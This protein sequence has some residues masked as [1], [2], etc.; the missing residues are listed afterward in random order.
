MN[1]RKCLI[2][3]LLLVMTFAKN[4]YLQAQTLKNFSHDPVR[5][6]AEMEAFLQATNKKDGEKLMER[7]MVPWTAG[8]FNAAQQETIYSTC[9]AMLK[10]RLKAFPDFSNYLNA[11]IGFSASTQSTQSFDNWHTGINKL[12][13]G[14]VRNFS[15]YLEVCYDLFTSNTLYSSPST[16]WKASNNGYSF[17]FDSLPKIVF[18]NMNLACYA[19]SDSSVIINTQGNYY[20]NLKKFYGKGG[21]VTWNRA[22]LPAKDVYAEL[23]RYQIDVSG[24]DFDADSVTFYN[25]QIFNQPLTGRL[26]EKILAS[27][28]IETATY[29]RFRSYNLNL[30]IKELVKDASYKGGFS[31]HGS[32]MIGSGGRDRAAT[33]IFS[34]SNKPFLKLQAQSFVMRTDRIVSDNAT[35]TFYLETDSIY[36]PGLEFKYIAKERE[37]S[38]IRPSGKSSGTPYYDSYHDIDMYFDAMVWKI[39]DP[40]IDMKMISGEGEVKLVFESSNFF[41]AQRYQRLQGLAEVNPLYTLKQY[42][43]KNQTKVVGVPEYALHLRM[44]EGQ[45]RNLFLALASQGFLT[46]DETTDRA[47]I[48]DRLYYYLSASVGKTD[49]DIIE[50]QSQISGKPNAT[51]NLLN[52]EIN[53]RGVPYVA[54]SD[55]QNVFVVPAEQELT[56]KKDRNFTFNGRV[57]AGRFDFIGKEFTFNYD[58]FNLHLKAVD[59]LSIK[60]PSDEPTADGRIK[61]IPIKSVVQNVTGYLNIDRANNKSSYQ[62]SPEYPIFKSDNQSYVYY[63]YPWIYNS[64]YNRNSFYFQVSPF[65]IDS[66]DNFK[67]EGLS[68]DGSLISAGIFP[69]IPEKLVIQND[70]SL[71][72]KRVLAD[73]GLPAYAGKGTYYEKLNLSNS[74]LRGGGRITYLNSVSESKDIVFFPDS[75]NADLDELVMTRKIIA[76]TEYP[77]GKARDVYMNWRPKNDKMF[78]Y[79]KATNFS[80]Y[81]GKVDHDGDLVLANTGLTG[82]GTISFEQAQILSNQFNFKGITLNADTS[83]F[84]LKSSETGILALSTTNM[85]SFIDFEKRFGEF[86][87]NGKGSY[88]TFPLNQYICYIEKFKW[89]MDDKNVEFGMTANVKDNTE[90]NIAGSEF[91]SINPAQDSLR[92]F[93]PDASY[94]LTD[95]L[96]KA[97]EVKEINVA[98][99]SIIPGDGK[100]V[101]E[102]STYIRTL[103]DA[104]VVANTSTRYHTMINSTINIASK[105]NYSGTGDYEYV[106]QLKVKHLM[107]LTQIG[108]DTSYQTFANGDVEDS[109]NFMLSPNIQYKGRLSIQASRPSP[110]FRGFA[111]ANHNCAALKQNWFGFAAEIDPKGVNVPVKA[112][113]NENG[114]K[115][116]S[117]IVFGKDSANVYATFMSTKRNA[118][119]QEIVSAEGLLSYDNTSKEFRL[120]PPPEEKDK[121]EDKGKDVPPKP[122]NEG[123]SFA[124]N[125]VTCNF[126]GEG[127]INLGANFGQFK[128]KTIG[129]VNYVPEDDTLYF[130][131]MTDLDFFFNDEAL[132]VIADLILT[133]PTLP[134]TNDNRPEF[135]N[136]LRNLMGREAADKYISD[137][138]LYGAPKKV[139]AEMQHSLFLSD[140]KMYW[141][142]ESLSYKSVGPIGIAY[143]GKQQ[144]NRMVRGYFEVA[145]KR[146]GDQF[147]LYFELDG[148]TWLFFNY[149]RGV[150]QAISS[151]TKFNEIINNMKPDKRVADDKGGLPAYQFLLSTDRKKNE[152]V[153]RAENK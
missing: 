85:K 123:N 90:M 51:L 10:K 41:R 95:Y 14:S 1:L 23:S 135:Q 34:R 63:D 13:K 96:I 70:Y 131:A 86:A 50:F 30:E 56:L 59:S 148:N 153:K 134:P 132:K 122:F 60:I 67:P 76:G 137:I 68:F 52:N 16:T 44:E 6:T 11:L 19:K 106:D 72:F 98:D 32:K 7:F 116:Y 53:M 136:G 87:S 20:P 46:Y 113:I 66:V 112:P 38:L 133:F 54:L 92:W 39:D 103:V 64:V 108:V 93:S 61:M 117:S 47:V 121:K 107:K 146:S 18:G 120:I 139:P 125:D 40:L 152:F 3:L 119:D 15:N 37:V 55:T 99:A 58:D 83:D 9:D 57:H 25:K 130:D 26:M 74:G 45:I 42:A 5:F 73:A 33:L 28:T 102:K 101:I 118:S 115:L 141:H 49:Y 78:L 97:K 149:Q 82:T 69:D 43:E 150:M 77:S 71:G 2:P 128:M 48:K 142:K 129:V 22:G 138:S 62:K 17:E 114:E 79:K 105:K 126:R 100:V 109:Q 88:V 24:S 94:N 4:G 104:K 111:R 91:V 31:M 147:N 81:D 27:T 140:L 110:F 35:V 21:T 84:R 29:P 65:T 8:K 36:H 145:R 144:V 75:A 89:L 143:M 80:L 124:L 127:N 12:L 151:D